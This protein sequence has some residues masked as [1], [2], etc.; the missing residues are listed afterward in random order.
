MRKFL[1]VTTAAVATSLLLGSGP[2]AAESYITAK[3]ALAANT[4]DY[5]SGR[6]EVT[7]EESGAIST[8]TADPRITEPMVEHA[9]PIVNGQQDWSAQDVV[10]DTAPHPLFTNLA[11]RAPAPMP[12][13]AAV[14]PAPDPESLTEE[15]YF[16]FD[17]AT[18]T[19]EGEAKIDRLAAVMRDWDLRDVNVAGHADRSGPPDYN[20]ALS[21]RRAQA[22]ADAL[23]VRGLNPVV[24]DTEW[25]G[26]SRPAVETP[27]GQRLEANRRVEVQAVE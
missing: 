27:D 24:M 21:Q 10:G 5:G 25:Y 3:P 2:A 4:T 17:R 18:L 20:E 15:I 19:P 6:Y 13:Q 22:V 14:P 8:T 26:E 12:Q 1:L 7:G 23:T 11:E 9:L 16:D